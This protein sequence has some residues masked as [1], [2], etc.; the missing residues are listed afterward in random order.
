MYQQI[1]LYQPVFKKQHKVFGA[2][3]LAQILAAVLVLLSMILGHARWTLAGMQV[4]AD[5]L[6]QQH[7]H[8]QTEINLLEAALQTPDSTS[9]DHE[10]TGL[11]TSIEQRKSL[12]QQFQLLSV[13]HRGGFADSF[14]TLAEQQVAGLW[15][16]GVT[17]DAV[18]R[19]EVRGTALDEKL[20]PRYLQQLHRN[21]L[22]GA[23]FETVSMM[24]PDTAKPHIQ[25]VLRNHK[26]S[27]SW[28]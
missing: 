6:E 15:L 18:G 8:I 17:L 27:S 12:L 10:I 21:S 26:E 19:M 2:A 20:I 1:N 16:D 9:I 22:S 28:R 14:R 23:A 13:E 5:R 7:E 11:T 4:S 25:F 24:R 3:T